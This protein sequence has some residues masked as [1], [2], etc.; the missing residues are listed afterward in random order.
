MTWDIA[1]NRSTIRVRS[2]PLASVANRCFSLADLYSQKGDVFEAITL[3]A[4]DKSTEHIPVLAINP[5]D[6]D[7]L[8]DRAIAAGAKLVV[9]DEALLHHLDH[10]LNQV[11]EID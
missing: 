10:F 9:A 3:L 2:C 6:N 7:K 4:K 1:S 11:L 8:R 5:N